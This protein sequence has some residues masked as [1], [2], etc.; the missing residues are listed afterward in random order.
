M[1]GIILQKDLYVHALPNHFDKP[2][3]SGSRLELP[4]KCFLSNR[5][6]VRYHENSTALFYNTWLFARFTVCLVV[7]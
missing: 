3:M 4:A 6:H 2:C 7:Y 5:V 1:Q